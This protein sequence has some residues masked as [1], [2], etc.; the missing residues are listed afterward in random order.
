MDAYEHYTRLAAQAG[1]TTIQEFAV[2][3][4]QSRHLRILR[5]ANM[6]IRVRAHCFPLALDEP[7]DVPLDFSPE[8]PFAMKYAGGH[9]GV[10][11]GTPIERFSLLRN[12]YEDDPGNVGRANFESPEGILA[13]QVLLTMVNGNIGHDVPV[14]LK[15]R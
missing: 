6:P 14:A 8:R 4:P 12:D 15:R 10:D 13:T 1:Y 3:I 9:K 11:D 7:C 5:Q 2:G